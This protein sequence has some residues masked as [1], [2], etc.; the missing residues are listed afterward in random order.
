ML[1]DPL[2][3]VHLAR[4]PSSVP[5]CLTRASPADSESPM[6]QYTTFNFI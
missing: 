4:S 2:V 1:D 5:S 6:P 3:L